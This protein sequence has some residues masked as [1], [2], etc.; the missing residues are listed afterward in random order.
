MFSDGMVFN[1]PESDMLPPPRPIAELFPPMR[2]SITVLLGIPPRRPDG[3]NCALENGQTI[4]RFEP[5]YVA[6]ARVLHDE[7]TGSDERSI[8]MGRK[9]LRLVLDTEPA[10]DLLTLPLARVV[11]DGSSHFTYDPQFIPPLIEIHA[12]EG[13]ALLLQRLLEILQEKSS[14]ITRDRGPAGAARL[15]SS[16][17]ASFWQLHAVN[18]AMAPLQHLLSAKRGHPEE[19]FLELSRLAGALCTFKLGSHP[20]DLPQYDHDDLSSCFNALDR[21]IREHLEII[22]PTHYVSIPL[23]PAETYFYHGEIADQRCLGRSQWILGL[24][25]RMGE[26]ELMVK[27]PSLV[28][29]CSSQFVRRLVEHAL[30]GLELKHLPTPPAAI[31]ATVE[32]QYFLISRSGPCWD[33]IMKTRSV[34]LYIPGDIPQPEIELLVVLES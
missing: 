30:P 16:E 13:L 6:E 4:S 3:F 2:D 27:T 17:I 31:R 33:H 24:R 22:V 10:G 15:A 25:A 7:N 20:R 28:K 5:R 29:L 34:G 14:A 9:N 18:S 12:S 32:T 1:M 21:H 23:N 11:R 19:L 26:A 8:R